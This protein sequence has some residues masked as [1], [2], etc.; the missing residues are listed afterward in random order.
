MLFLN[1]ILTAAKTIM[2]QVIA[3]TLPASEDA[4]LKRA[5]QMAGQT[6][7]TL[8][9]WVGQDLPEDYLHHKGWTGCMIEDWLGATAGSESEPDFPHLGVELKTVPLKT[10]GQPKETTFVCTVPIKSIGRMQWRESS[11]FKKLAK[12]LWIPI[13]GDR[14]IP[15]P[16]RRIGMPLLWEMTEEIEVALRQDWEEFA[17]RICLGKI[18]SITAHQGHFLQIR[19]KAANASVRCEG[20]NEEGERVKTLPRGFYLRTAFTADLFNKHYR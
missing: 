13:E 14:S 3:L 19:P 6:L 17:E 2:N 4:L 18:D 12:V 1:L 20:V 7:E 10:N 16:E 9:E 5:E 8:A 15:I 11:V